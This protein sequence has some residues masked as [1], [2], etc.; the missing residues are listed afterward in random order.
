MLRPETPGCCPPQPHPRLPE[1]RAGLPVIPRQITGFPH[2]RRAMLGAIP[3][4]PELEGWRADGASDL[5]VMLLEAWAYVLDITGFYDGIVANRAYL[6]TVADDVVMRELVALIGYVPRPAMASRVL[7]A[8][9]AQGADKVVAPAA[10]GLRSQAFDAEPA[11][12]FELPAAADIWPQRNQWPLAPYRTAYF[13]GTLRFLPG[14]GPSAGMV[15]ALSTP[16]SRFVGRVAAVDTVAAADG[17]KYQTVRFETGDVSFFTGASLVNLTAA[18]LPVPASL[19]PLLAQDSALALSGGHGKAILDGLYPQ[20]QRNTVFAIEVDGVLR[21][22]WITAVKIKKV[23]VASGVTVPVTKLKFDALGTIGA[24]ASVKFHLAPRA[25]G[26]PTRPAETALTLDMLRPSALLKGP[27]APLREAPWS[28]QAIAVG[29]KAA[30]ALLSGTVT[31]AADGSARFAPDGAAAAFAEPLVAPVSLFGNVVQAVRGETI[32]EE[33]LGSADASVPGQR[34]KL[35]KKPLT[36]IEDPSRSLGRA[37][38]LAVRVDGIEWVWVESFYGRGPDERIY[39]VE[40]A[41]DGTATVVFG[42]GVRG[43]RPT[44][45]VANVNASYRWG[46]GAAKPPP[47]SIKQFSRPARGLSR[48]AGPLA[49]F[50]GADAESAGELRTAAPG[51]MLSLGRAV[52]VADF[53]AMV[54]SYSGIANTAVSYSW[55]P[56]ARG[57]MM[58]VWIIADAGDPST[59]LADYLRARAVPG[60]AIRVTPATPVVVPVFDITIEAASDRSP[61]AVRAAVRTALFDPRTGYLGPRRIAISAPLFRSHLLAAI[62]AVPG[63]AAVKSIMTA[64][65][66]MQQAMKLSAGQWFDF[67]ANGHVL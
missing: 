7:V 29:A 16:T 28:G 34:F 49:A 46:A 21:P 22:A 43:A 61:D 45:G 58:L 17:L 65:G 62:H 52:S 31:I 53:E 9:E 64:T 32:G 51:A 11:Q 56:V 48:V 4:M 44:S 63:V 13:D 39:R 5:G 15:I 12:V 67:L 27:V 19:T 47:G 14:E 59:A 35:K 42:D 41:A 55:D 50:G 24:T 26:R 18:S 20:V 66:E 37:P 60:L 10:T 1:I 2:Y 23:S 54:R 38:Q 30:G 8:L 36:W 6:G 40:M 3:A 25:L 57:A 33:V